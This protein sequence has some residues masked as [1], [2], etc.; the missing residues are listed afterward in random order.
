M[1]FK[2]LVPVGRWGIGRVNCRGGCRVVH[3]EA[4][5][6]SCDS[7]AEPRVFEVLRLERLVPE[8]GKREQ[9]AAVQIL[10]TVEVQAD[11]VRPIPS[12]WNRHTERPEIH[13]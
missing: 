6:I 8:R 11:V 7:R 13:R 1:G 2:R 5:P 9:I 10:V 4:R 3:Q 12:E